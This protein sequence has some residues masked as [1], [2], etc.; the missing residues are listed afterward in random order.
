ME[1]FL[2]AAR[3]LV[4]LARAL[5]CLANLGDSLLL[6]R[7][8]RGKRFAASEKCNHN[9]ALYSLLQHRQD[10]QHT[11]TH[12][13]HIHA[14]THMRT[15]HTHAHTHIRTPHIYTCTHTH[16]HAHTHTLHTLTQTHRHTHTHTHAHTHTR[17]HARTHARMHTHTHAH[18]DT[19]F[20]HTHPHTNIHTH[21]QTD[22]HRHVHTCTYMH[23]YTPHI[24]MHARTHARMHVRIHTHSLWL[25]KHT[26]RCLTSKVTAHKR[27]DVSAGNK[28]GKNRNKDYGNIQSHYRLLYVGGC[29][30]HGKIPL[31]LTK[32]N[33][34]SN[35]CQH[36]CQVP[37][38]YKMYTI[39]H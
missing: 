13:P 8:W 32:E 15:P 35:L 29:K 34:C 9:H 18:T 26:E 25:A 28:T 16:T 30:V 24:R 27:C 11:L 4:D 39:H 38:H 7:R 36:I 37:K 19:Q 6:F 10:T 23:Q 3:A 1:S 21:I 31:T 12:T 2:N 20:I 17:S 14:H 22:T 5:F 33:T